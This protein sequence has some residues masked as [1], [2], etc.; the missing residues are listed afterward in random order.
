MNMMSDFRILWNCFGVWNRVIDSSGN[1]TAI[2]FLLYN[3]STFGG[4]IA[5]GICSNQENKQNDSQDR[6]I[7]GV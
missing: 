1:K 5:M 2:F 3:S 7:G 6:E 4:F